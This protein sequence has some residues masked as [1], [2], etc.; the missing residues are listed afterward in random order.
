MK[1]IGWRKEINEFF[2]GS[3][4]HENEFEMMNKIKFLPF[5]RVMAF[6]GEDM[7][8]VYDVQSSFV[9]G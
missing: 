3:F 6:Y 2:F 9:K 5:M 4:N 7:F 1:N 8:V